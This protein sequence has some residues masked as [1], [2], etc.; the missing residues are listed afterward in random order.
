M[1]SIFRV[2]GNTESR[3]VMDT[4]ETAAH[5]ARAKLWNRDFFLLWQG[6]FVSQFGSQ[7]HAIALMFWVKHATGSAT[8]MGTMLM[9][10]MLP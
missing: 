3:R 7:V 1:T 2:K 6:Q 8:L 5:P 4:A 9:L 10:S